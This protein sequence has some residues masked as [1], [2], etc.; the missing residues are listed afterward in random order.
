MNDSEFLEKALPA[1][2]QGKSGTEIARMVG[3]KN[4]T[5]V[6]AR[7][8]RLRKIL[9]EDLVPNLKRGRQPVDRDELAKLAKKIMEDN[10]KK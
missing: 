7:F 1:V 8:T 3:M 5:K 2:Y 10:N 6:S 4:S 9:G